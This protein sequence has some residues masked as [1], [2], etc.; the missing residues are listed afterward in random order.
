[1]K[2]KCDVFFAVRTEFLNIVYTS[3][4]FK[5]FIFNYYI[6]PELKSELLKK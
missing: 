6:I 4:R 2:V 1:M 3:L 5:G